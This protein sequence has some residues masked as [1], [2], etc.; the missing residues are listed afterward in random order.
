MSTPP[1]A[2][3]RALRAYYGSLDAVRLALN[4]ERS[5]GVPPSTAAAAERLCARLGLDPARYTLEH[6]HPRAGVGKK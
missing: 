4:E 2:T 5:R 3:L 6:C 1:G